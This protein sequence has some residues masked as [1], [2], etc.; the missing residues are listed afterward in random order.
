MQA[1][2]GAPAVETVD[3]GRIGPELDLGIR[4]LLADCFAPGFMQTR[5]PLRAVSAFSVVSRQGDEVL[6]NVSVFLR[7]IRCGPTGVDV[8]GIGNVAVARARR[9]SGL[10]E[11]L[12]Q[13]ALAE[14]QRRGRQFG[15]LFCVPRLERFYASM[16]W[17]RRAG[18]VFMTVADGQTA[19]IP[20]KDI[21]MVL[22]MG[23]A[24][25]PD[26]EIHLQGPH[27]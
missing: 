16:G 21:A 24:A 26:G 19:P 1:E 27:W 15:L 12:M 2:G 7:T 4:R 5:H 17:R 9:G 14:A 22:E 13:A 3:E 10:C 8:A 18:R 11:A 25:F 20:D 6:G 23:A